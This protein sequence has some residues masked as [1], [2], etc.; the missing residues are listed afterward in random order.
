MNVSTQ[1]LTGAGRKREGWMPTVMVIAM[2]TG[3]GLSGLFQ[4]VP[5]EVCRNLSQVKGV[6]TLALLSPKLNYHFGFQS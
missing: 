1:K 4:G 6:Y 5:L 3:F 2:A